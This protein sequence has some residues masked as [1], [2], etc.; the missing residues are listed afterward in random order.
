LGR[1]YSIAG[2]VQIG[3]RIGRQ[4]GFPTANLDVSGLELPPL[5]VYAVRVHHRERDWMGALNLGRRPT[6]T[7]GESPVRCEVHLLD[8]HE[9]IY[10]DHL[11]V[12]F[13][14]YLRPE[15]RFPSVEALRTQIARDIAS[16]RARFG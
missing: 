5:G 3:D 16:V 8:F 15:Q 11:R 13:T 12:E 1:P 4:L 2:P 10:G 6:V 14:A 7:G 9:D